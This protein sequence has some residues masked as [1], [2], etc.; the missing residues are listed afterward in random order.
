MTL[1]YLIRIPREE[2]WLIQSWSS[3][4]GTVINS[5]ILYWS[6]CGR[7]LH[8]KWSTSYASL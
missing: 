2:P 7:F 6:V 1:V 5:Q 8:G 3:A 4:C